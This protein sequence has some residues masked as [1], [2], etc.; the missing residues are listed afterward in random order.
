MSLR[1]GH[2]TYIIEPHHVLWYDSM[3]ADGSA[4]LVDIGR[5]CSI[6]ANCT[7][8]LSH[9]DVTRVTTSPCETA[10]LWPH[11]RGNKSSFS[12]GDIVIGNDVWIGANCTILDNVRIGDGAV[13]AAG[14][15]VTK[16]VPPYAIV[17]GNPASV[18][19]HRFSPERV[20]ELLELRW[21]DLEDPVD[22]G[23]DLWTDDIDAFITRARAARNGGA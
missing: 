13:V 4:P 15:V 11:Q 17:G 12:R 20:E 18:I 10:S 22:H 1:T 9:H 7:F 5:Y 16:D 2:K 3:K 21:W 14:A 19:R 23:L 6:A 8:V